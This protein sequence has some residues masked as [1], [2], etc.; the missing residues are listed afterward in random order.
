MAWNE[1]GNNNSNNNGNKDPWGNRNN[2]NGPPDLDEMLKKLWR[3]LSGGGGNSSGGNNPPVKSPFSKAGIYAILAVIV[4]VYAFSGFY[5]VDE[6][7]RAVVLRL[8]A[9]HTTVG[10]GLHWAPTFIDQPIKVD[11]NSIERTNVDATMLTKDENI[12]IVRLGVQYRIELPEDYLFNVTSPEDTITEA[13]E[14]ALREVVGNTI[15]DDIITTGREQLKADTLTILQSTMEPYATGLSVTQLTLEEAVPPSQVKDAF[16]DAIKAREDEEKYINTAQ[17]Y[18]N[19]VVPVAEGAAAR[20][21]EVARA[22]EQSQ[23]AKA[24]GDIAKFNLLLPEYTAAPDVT[25]QRL[26]LESMERVYG[27][28]NKVLIDVEGGNNMLYLPLDQLMK[29]QRNTNQ[30]NS[31]SNNQ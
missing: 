27:N 6:K 7:E 29:Q 20:M 30:N 3:Q 25:R 28:V 13:A 18:Q 12:V 19:K 10:S 1:P 11:I 5:T 31:G 15:M 8:G 2:Q 17:S 24:T 14:S 26:Y 4:V 9:Y 21:I 16:D 23:I 22:Y